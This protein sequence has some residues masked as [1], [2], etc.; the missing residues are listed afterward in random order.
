[1]EELIVIGVVVSVAFTYQLVQSAA[2][3]GVVGSYSL[4]PETRRKAQAAYKIAV[5]LVSVF[6]FVGFGMAVNAL[7]FTPFRGGPSIWASMYTI[8][9]IVALVVTLAGSL[10]SL[11]WGSKEIQQ[12]SAVDKTEGY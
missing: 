2:K 8:M 4:S 3:R 9:L 7:F 10:R 11:V 1:M 5:R 12:M 6:W